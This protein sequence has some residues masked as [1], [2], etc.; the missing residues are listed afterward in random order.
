MCDEQPRQDPSDHNPKSNQSTDYSR[1]Q[2]PR[3][4]AHQGKSDSLSPSPRVCFRRSC[5]AC[6][7]TMRLLP[8]RYSLYFCMGNRKQGVGTHRKVTARRTER[9]SDRSDWVN[10]PKSESHREVEALRLLL[11]GAPLGH[12]GLAHG[13]VGGGRLHRLGG[14]AVLEGLGHVEVLHRQ[15]V[16]QGLHGG[17][18]SLPH[19]GDRTPLGE[20]TSVLMSA[21]RE[22]M[23]RVGLCNYSIFLSISNFDLGFR[24]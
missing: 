11:V 13:R 16:L 23:D 6:S 21:S 5:L 20:R 24:V 18:Q 15:H 17:V 3:G 4:L 1:C 8:F 14:L 2:Q 9:V 10:W 12:V 7:F 22:H 19:L